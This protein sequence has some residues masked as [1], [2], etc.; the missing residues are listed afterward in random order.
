MP[1]PYSADLRQRVIAA[2][3]A[4][5]WTRREIAQQFQISET[6]LYE[7]LQRW[8]QC[9]SYAAA[10]HA[11]GHAS[12][13]D[14]TVLRELVEEQNDAT[15]SEY[16][17]RLAERTGRLYSISMLSRV[18]KELKLSRKERRYVHRNTSG[19]RSLPSA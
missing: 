17:Q 15:L 7:W 9:G 2:C 10:P 16:A 8:R 11:G 4:G 14:E 12:H 13:L 19:R 1:Q 6:T 18:L 5:E 3:E